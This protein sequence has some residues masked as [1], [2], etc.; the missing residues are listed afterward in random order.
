VEDE[1]KICAVECASGSEPWNVLDEP[2]RRREGLR[3]ADE[4]VEEAGAGAAET[5]PL[6]GDREVLAGEAADEK[7][8]CLESRSSVNITSR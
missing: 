4:L 8:E 5:G 3:D 1:G 2:P 6:A 7:I